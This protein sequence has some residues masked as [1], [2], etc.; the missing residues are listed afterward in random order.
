MTIDTEKRTLRLHACKLIFA[1]TVAIL[2]IL[3]FYRP[4]RF[5]LRGSGVE[6]WVLTCLFLILY[7]GYL[8]YLRIR[9]TGYLYASDTALPGM[10][11]FRH[12]QL[13][14]LN[15][16]QFSVEMPHNELYRYEVKKNRLGL[17]EEVIL[18]QR[19]G[20]RIFKYPP[21]SL[22]ILTRKEREQFMAMLSRHSE[23]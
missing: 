14:L 10:L 19:H 12:F 13:K 2:C 4:I 5:W 21:F 23:K 9:K 17:L 8:L 6:A 16:K 3:S 1:L 7:V 11:R 20:N 22:T 18:W 15:R